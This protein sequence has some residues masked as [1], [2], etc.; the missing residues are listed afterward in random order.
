VR[1]ATGKV[2]P[3]ASH[4]CK[5]VEVVPGVWTA[6]FHDIEDIEAL[7]K[8]STGVTTVIN[9][10][11]DKCPTK[12]GSYGKGVDV[13]VIDL[14]DDPEDYKKIDAMPEGPEKAKKKAN[15]PA[16]PKEQLAGDAKKDF[17]RVVDL[18]EKAK[19]SGG[20]SLVHC[21]ASLSRSA[22]FILAYLMKTEKLSAVEAV[23]KMKGQWD[24]VWPNDT[25]VKQLVEY[26]KE[27]S[28]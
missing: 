4:G 14:L 13:V 28:S 17:D 20:A 18:M 22:A 26:E 1:E 12:Q 21:H 11:P 7:Q 19:A 23:K 27:I 8:V 16:F 5:P 2:R 24:A 10:A 6:H 25:F 3:P 9:C 15:L